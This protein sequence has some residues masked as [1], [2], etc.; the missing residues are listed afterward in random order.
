MSWLSNLEKL[1]ENQLVAQDLVAS[2]KWN[3]LLWS[4]NQYI[5]TKY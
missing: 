3:Q 4:Q 5:E 2:N 1:Q